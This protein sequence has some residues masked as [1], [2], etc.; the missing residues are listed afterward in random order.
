MRRQTRDGDREGSLQKPSRMRS[1]TKRGQ[2][3]RERLQKGQRTIE[4]ETTKR[5]Q[6]TR[7]RITK[8]KAIRDTEEAK[9]V[10]DEPRQRQRVQ[11]TRRVQGVK[12]TL[13]SLEIKE[14]EEESK[15]SKEQ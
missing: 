1:P 9:Q 8:V 5:D 6:R 12:K 2:R 3:D 10:R 14:K 4:Q 13:A 11:G 7:N 15:S